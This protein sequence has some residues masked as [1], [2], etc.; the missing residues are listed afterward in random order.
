MVT[1]LSMATAGAMAEGAIDTEAARAATAE[2]R[3]AA[4]RDDHPAAI[5]AFLAAL[6]HDARLVSEVG[7]ELAFQKLWHEEHD[8]AIFY[9]RRYLARHPGERNR[10]ARKGLALAYSWS[11][12]QDRAI[13]LYRELVAEDPTDLDARLGLG[14]ALVWDNQLHAGYQELRAIEQE[15]AGSPG[16]RGAGQF[17][18]T[19]L[20]EYDPHLD[21]RWDGIWDSD[22]LT[23]HRITALGRKGV[24]PALLE[25][26]VSPAWYRQP[27]QPG[28]AA[29]RFR[30]GLV[31]PL[32]HDWALHAYGWVDRFTSDGPL[33]QD[34]QELDW[35][36]AGGDAWLTWLP[37]SRWR[38]DLGAGSQVV[39]TYEAFAKRLHH[40]QVNLSADWRL[41]R[42]WTLS[43]AVQY[44]DYSDDNTRRRGSARLV[45]HRP[46][47][48][49][50][51]A[52]TVLYYMDY[53][54][55]YPGGYWAPDW[56]RN[57]SLSLRVQR[58]WQ[59]VVAQ[60][61]G[62]YG[63][64]REAGS[65]A[66]AVGGIHGHLGWRLAPGWLVSGDL[67][68]SRSR[69]TSDRGYERTAAT[70]RVRALF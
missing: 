41:A 15:H 7:D 13:A 22:E 25:A 52:G 9:F 24:G 54:Q 11:G 5:A 68:Y 70:L 32:A 19:V 59:R 69:F 67:G 8:K 63:L 48:W 26:G 49:D 37:T 28:V 51:S 42:R 14:R 64:E 31:T 45:Y 27:G 50:W 38:F 57:G 3:A 39:E 66:I 10:D 2:A 61:D 44:A 56:V 35:T 34:G 30:L 23:I 18:L 17:L 62:S 55:P 60:L 47:T 21:L 46:G 12:R 58:R 16:A 43:G 33:P 53:E 40:E 4:G 65:E 36:R 20:D 1:L 6:N 29:P